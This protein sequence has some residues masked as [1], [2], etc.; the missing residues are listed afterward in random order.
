[1]VVPDFFRG[2]GRM[3][4]GF[5]RPQVR[6]KGQEGRGGGGASAELN[7]SKAAGEEGN[8][9]LNLLYS[10]TIEGCAHRW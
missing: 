10:R 5:A 6:G 9:Q 4:E 1:V 8:R 7:Y 2:K 3:I